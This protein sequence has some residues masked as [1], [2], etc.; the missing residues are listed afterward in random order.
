MTMNS[1][2]K[3]TYLNNAATSWPKPKEVYNG[4]KACLFHP[5]DESL[6]SNSSN[7]SN[8]L[9]S[10][11]R[12]KLAKLISAPYPNRI[13][14][15]YNATYAINQVLFGLNY[16]INDLVISSVQEHNAVLRPVLALRE[17]YGVKVELLP[18]NEFGLIDIETALKQI[19]RKPK[20]VILSHASNVTGTIQPIAEIFK[21]A[22]EVGAVT[23][24]DA[25]QTIG[26]IPFILK[27]YYAD[28]IIF[29]GHKYLLGPTGIAGA[30]ISESINPATLLVGGSGVMSESET[31]PEQYPIKYEPGTHNFV[32][33]AGLSAALDWI[34]DN[35]KPSKAYSKYDEILKLLRNYPE[36]IINETTKE[37][38]P[39][40]SFIIKNWLV[41]DISYILQSS[42][43]II[44]R[45]GLHC[46]PLI[47]QYLKTG[48]A[49]C[50]RL[51]PSQFTKSGDLDRLAC[52]LDIICK[53]K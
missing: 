45:S 25:A 48:S 41:S 10:N 52:A 17:R 29:T 31:M 4:I 49:G 46:A 27:D 47:H 16:K 53:S 37:T 12:S 33:V 2:L 24:L 42:Y 36:I 22:K 1:R 50:L 28:A 14:F 9:L 13:F 35:W 44:C 30:Y 20:V 39:V 15:T 8:D 34:K 43:N 51:S 6:R 19:S 11:T 23:I 26:I 5:P 18:I 40:V 7:G 21:A 32:G 3:V 38:T